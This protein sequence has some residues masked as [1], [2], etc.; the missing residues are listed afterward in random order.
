MSKATGAALALTLASLAIASLASA[1]PAA[2]AEAVVVASTAPGYA[3]GQLVPDGASVSV[4]D[5]ANALFLFANGRMVRVK[6][7]FEGGLDKMPES[8]NWNGVGSL[9]GGERFFQTDLG[10]ARA[11][12]APMQKGAEQIFAVDPGLSGT[13][14]VK[15]GGTAMLQRPQDPALIPA[16][17]RDPAR[18]TAVTVRWDKSDA[19]PWPKELPMKDGQELSVSGPDGDNEDPIGG[20]QALYSNLAASLQVL[21]EKRLAGLNIS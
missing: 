3:Q 2:A 7:P 19:V 13:Q 16:T 12:G 4:P 10:A 1:P 8:S 15:T 9:V 20:D 18:G 14:C 6:G 11:L 5:G 17:L 21:I